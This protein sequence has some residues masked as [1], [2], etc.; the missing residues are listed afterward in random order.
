MLAVICVLEIESMRD[1]HSISARWW[2]DSRAIRA[3]SKGLL[4]AQEQGKATDGLKLQHFERQQQVLVDGL[5]ALEPYTA[6]S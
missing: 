3:L 6:G 2:Y 4:G 5:T 1:S